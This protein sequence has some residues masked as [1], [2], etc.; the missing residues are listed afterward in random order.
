M[1]KKSKLLTVAAAIAIAVLNPISQ[2]SAKG[3]VFHLYSNYQSE[4]Q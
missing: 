1:S 2:A 4:N 3:D